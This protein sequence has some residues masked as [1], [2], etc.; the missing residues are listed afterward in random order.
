MPIIS[1]E[2]GYTSADPKT[3][4]YGNKV[5]NI[6]QGL[7]AARMWLSNTIAGV[8]TSILYD[9][10]ND[11]TNISDCESNFG[12]VVNDYIPANTTSPFT[13]KPMFIA[14][15]TLQTTIGNAEVSLGRVGNVSIVTPPGVMARQEDV[16]VV[17]FGGYPNTTANATCGSASQPGQQDCGYPGISAAQCAAKGCCFDDQ[18]SGPWCSYP[19]AVT[20]QEYVFAAWSNATNQTCVDPSAPGP[21]SDCGFYGIDQ[22]T[23][24]NTR[25]CCWDPSPDPAG[26][27]C[28]FGPPVSPPGVPVSFAVWPAP[29]DQCWSVVGTFG[30]DQGSVCAVDGVVA[31]N[32]T[33]A[34]IYLL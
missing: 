34:P 14:A 27:Q 25:R 28:Y 22:N 17:A 12:S 23:C 9:W 11:G 18:S 5:D 33:D 30:D 16:F 26:P 21:R 1:G 32:V 8:H 13:P 2:W 6:T 7:Y 4:G 24:V 29:S 10:K 15:Y 3:C 19:V 20:Q 31:L